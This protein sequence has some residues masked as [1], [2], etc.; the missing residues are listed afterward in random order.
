MLTPD[1][2]RLLVLTDPEIG[3]MPEVTVVRPLAEPDLRDEPWLDPLHVALPHAGHLRGNAERRRVAVQRL[4]QLQQLP[5]LCVVE[6]RADVAD[7]TE[8]VPLVHREDER[9]ERAGAAPGAARI[10]G[11]DELLAVLRLD[12]QPVARALAFLVRAVDALG[13]DP[14]EPPLLSGREQ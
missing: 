1:L 12:L 13:D 5:D 14:L 10:A 11:D 3:R 8:L 7:V 4:Q 6:A 2:R 9:A